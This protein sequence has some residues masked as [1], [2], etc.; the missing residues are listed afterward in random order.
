MG[1]LKTHI[2]NSAT[3]FYDIA[4]YIHYIWATPLQAVIAAAFVITNLSW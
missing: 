1:D 2:E 4:L 3:K